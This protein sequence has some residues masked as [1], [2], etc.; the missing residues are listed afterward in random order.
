V[1][2]VL[3]NAGLALVT[4][5]DRWVNHRLAL[6]NKLFHA[7]RAGV[8]VVATDVGELART[9]R[10]HDLGELYRPGDAED[11]VRAIGR[12]IE[13]YPELQ[14]KV[15][16]AAAALSWDTDGEVLRASYAGLLAPPE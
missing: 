10:E 13:R 5:S 1:D 12:A 14:T 6:P 16:D 2:A 11:L 4:H 7:V 3:A 9:V 8:P 15:R